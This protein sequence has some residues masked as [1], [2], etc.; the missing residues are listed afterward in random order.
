MPPYKCTSFTC[1]QQLFPIC[2][3]MNWTTFPVN[4]SSPAMYFS[5]ARWWAQG[6]WSPRRRGV[7]TSAKK[8]RQKP[9]SPSASGPCVS[10]SFS[11]CNR[12]CS[13]PPSPRRQPRMRQ[14]GDSRR[15]RAT[16]GGLP[17]HASAGAQRPHPLPGMAPGGRDTQAGQAGQGRRRGCPG[18][19]FRSP[20]LLR[21]RA[22]HPQV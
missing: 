11:A 7:L 1:H 18:G 12:C 6:W 19:P 3:A 8:G 10:P 2:S 22:P 17:P 9:C 4:C 14:R 21:R 16:K 15:R 20:A 13:P 5:K